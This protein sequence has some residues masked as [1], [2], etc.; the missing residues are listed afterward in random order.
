[1]DPL[2]SVIIP[3]FNEEKYISS[4]LDNILQQDYPADRLEVFIIDRKSTRLN[5]SH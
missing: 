2:V 5:S 1:M 3:S 4:L